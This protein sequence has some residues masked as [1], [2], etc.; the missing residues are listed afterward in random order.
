LERNDKGRTLA[1]AGVLLIAAQAA[2][3]YTLS[4]GESIP[5]AHPLNEFPSEVGNWVMTG[6]DVLDAETEAVLK[7]D[8][9]LNRT[10]TNQLDGRQ[11]SLYVAYFKT[12]QTG[13]APHSPRNCLPGNGWVQDSAQITSLTVPGRSQ[14]IP[15]NEYLV[16][17]GPAKALV[18]YWYQSHGRVVASEYRAKAYTVVDSLRYHRSD[19]ALIRVVVNIGPA[20][21]A[22]AR[23]L[24]VDFVQHCF[25]LLERALPS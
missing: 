10:Y 21:A 8:D 23:S 11:A 1:V 5:L 7:A 24:A 19:T 3:F 12:Q 16:A 9:Y 20:G 2:M 17:R 4:H 25:P 22:A 18:F 15:V 14:P 6:E 13:Q